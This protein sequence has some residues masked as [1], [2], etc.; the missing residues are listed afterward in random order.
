[1]LLGVLL[2][3]PTLWAG[4]FA[5]DYLQIA[6]LEGWSVPPGGPLD[7]YTFIP[8]D[9]AGVAELRER[10]AP[11][12][13]A[14]DLKLSFFRPLS[15]A[16]MGL[17]HALWGRNAFPYH[18]HSLLWY[19]AMLAAAAALLARAAPGP[20]ATVALL[21]F[22]LDDAHALS[23][24]FLAARNAVVSCAAV[25]LGLI[26]H[27][28]WRT[29][30]W[31]PGAWLAPLLAV[32][33][34]AAGEMGLAALA[35]LV[36]WELCE[37]RP[38]R[39]RALAPTLL[40]IAAYFVVYRLTQS[41][42]RGS[43]A[44]LDPFGEPLGYLRQLPGRLLLLTGSLLLGTPLDLA[45]GDG[46]LWLPLKVVGAIAGLI[47][48]V[49]LPGALRRMAPG[50]A[51]VV[52]W[53]GLGAAAALFVSIPGL[54]GERL[55][56]AASL[57]G[58]VVVAALLRD[59][60]TLFRAHRCRVWAAVGLAVLG[61]PNLVTPALALPAKAVLFGSAFEGYRRLAREAE[62]GASPPARVVVVA[63]DDL[64]PLYLL[65]IR[66]FE[67][68][69]TP[70]ELR[71]LLRD[72]RTPGTVLSMAA[73]G[74]R[75]RR[76]AVDELVLSTPDGTLLDGTWAE[77]FRAPSRPL[78]QGAVIRTAGMTATVLDDRDGRPTRV[79]FRFDRPLDDTS[80]V[81]LIPTPGRMRRLAMPPIGQEI[82]IPRQ[83]PF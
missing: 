32:A 39:L 7:L 29:N 69:R 81:F 11:W 22:C 70:A 1:M 72:W 3:V 20:L 15:S 25:W 6:R 38:G 2:V 58:A 56:F 49:W 4:F 79:A 73:T 71:R 10:G 5:D 40:V 63:F 61:L 53:M 34:L 44:Y 17:D 13:I 52:R 48:T 46:R 77:L 21:I 80:L 68:N 24:G 12:F 55:L 19:A 31:R 18:L 8:P 60:W 26:A 51:A 54:P 66:A 28:R 47:V 37:R 83:H 82:A 42:A 36:A 33:G 9:P 67:E 14:S 65:A 59:A 16:L 75:L 50:E 62:V 74:H 35:Y 78:P 45:L 57:G 43:G 23:V 76:T 41:G 27:L 64:F 30:G